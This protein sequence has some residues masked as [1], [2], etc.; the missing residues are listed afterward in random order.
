MKNKDFL[1]S[2]S[3]TLVLLNMITNIE[4]IL[5]LYM[6]ILGYDLGSSSVKASLVCAE[7]G[8]CVATAFY[9]K[10]EAPILSREPGWA[11]QDPDAWWEYLKAATAEVLASAGT[12]SIAAIGISYQ[13]HGLVRLPRRPL[14][15]EGLRRAG[16]GLVPGASSQLSRQLHRRQACLGKGE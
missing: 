11:E 10:N 2:M 12:P 16:K 7:S 1:K 4:K 6:L 5:Y 3:G 8:K 13:M 15:A 14:R 9:P